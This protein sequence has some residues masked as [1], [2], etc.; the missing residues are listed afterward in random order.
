MVQLN[1][2]WMIYFWIDAIL[3]PNRKREDLNISG[4][5]KYSWWLK[6][7]TAGSGYCLYMDQE[8]VWDKYIMD[9]QDVAN[10]LAIWSGAWK[11]QE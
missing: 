11:E 6:W 4:L 10:N 3:A 5:G 1:M 8:M 9:F 2:S 7:W